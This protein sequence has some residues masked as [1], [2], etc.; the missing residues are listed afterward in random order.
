MLLAFAPEK[1]LTNA[2]NRLQYRCFP[3]KFLKFLGTPIL[4]SIIQGCLAQLSAS[5]LKI[6]LK[7]MSYIF[8]KNVWSEKNIYI[9]IN[10]YIYILIFSQRKL[11][12]RNGTCLIFWKY[13]LEPW[14]NGTLLKFQKNDIQNSG[15]TKFS[16]ISGNGLFYPYISLLFQEV[17]KKFL[18][19]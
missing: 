18:I 7:E 11:F 17:T 12:W 4:S 19:L 1:Q 2:K 13:I 15:I 10:I 5:A 3:L 6:F 9:F 16:Y 14:H 8:P